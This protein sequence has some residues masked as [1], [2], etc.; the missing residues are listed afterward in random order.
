MTLDAD[1][2][3]ERRRLKRRLFFWRAAAILAAVVVLAV[4][5]SGPPSKT[6]GD[7]LALG[8]HIARVTI[9]GVI[10]DER[11]K[12]KLLDKLADASS[13]KAV[14]VHINSPGGTTAGG[15]MLYNS[16]R[17]ISEKKPV[18]AV[19]GTAATSAA[20]MA[21]IAS[22]HIVA[23]GSTITGSVGVIFQ[24]PDVSGLLDKIGVKVEEIKSGP[25]KAV[26]SPYAPVDEAGRQASQELVAE[27]QRWFLSLVTDR[28]KLSPEALE[29]VKTGRVFSGRQALALGLIDGLGDENDAKAWLEKTKDIDATTR[30]IDWETADT[31]PYSLIRIATTMLNADMRGLFHETLA[32]FGKTASL[33]GQGLEG[34]ISIGRSPDHE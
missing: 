13:A 22:D 24:W 9:N 29:A 8:G 17:R 15:E 1:I 26:P 28:R 31:S 12:Q 4:V 21:G 27:A 25:L 14:I 23:R 30:V 32:F 11:D 18:V 10:T 5:V 3:I 33:A 34:L 7:A 2:I 20:Y 19:L 6:S 16:L